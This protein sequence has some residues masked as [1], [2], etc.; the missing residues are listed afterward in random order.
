[1]AAFDPLLPLA[2]RD[3]THCEKAIA[4]SD[5]SNSSN[6]S[7]V[8][9]QGL[10]GLRRKFKGPQVSGGGCLVGRD[11]DSYEV[12]FADEMGEGPSTPI[13]TPLLE[14][15]EGGARFRAALV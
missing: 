1:M 9:P 15:D 14:E 3:L 7:K 6:L 12:D 11:Y 13:R 2:S 4:D 10:A 5:A 8:S